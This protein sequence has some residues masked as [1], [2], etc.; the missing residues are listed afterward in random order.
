MAGTN[1]G[2]DNFLDPRER[3]INRRAAFDGLIDDT[4]TFSEL[5]QLIE[6]V[7]A[8][9]G[10]EIEAQP[11]P[12][13]ADGRILSDA[14]RT[15]KIEIAFGRYRCRSQP[16]YDR[17]RDRIHRLPRAADKRTQQRIA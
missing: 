16:N 4:I 7:L 2:H 12:R 1:P 5:E 17:G 13:K 11:D 10:V 3:H 6:L 8:R 9:I 15:A 14:E